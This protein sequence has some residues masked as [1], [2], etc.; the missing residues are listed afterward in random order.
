MNKLFVIGNP[1][2]Q[3]KSP[4]IHNYWIKKHSLNATYHKL[5]VDEEEIP[6][7]LNQVKRGFIKGINITIPFKQAII[8]YLDYLEPS[9]QKSLAVNT[10]FMKGK[11]LVG[12]NTDG[13]GF[14]K[15]ITDDLKFTLKKN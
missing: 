11:N 4:S 7:I 10:V 12:A 3:S 2:S 8:S 6:S 9:A 13:R 14:F 5:K 1:V 15:S